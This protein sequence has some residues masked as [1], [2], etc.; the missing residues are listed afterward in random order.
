MVVVGVVV[1]AA[2]VVTALAPIVLAD[3]Q[4]DAAVYPVWVYPLNVGNVHAVL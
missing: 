3:D 4:D 1:V 2:I